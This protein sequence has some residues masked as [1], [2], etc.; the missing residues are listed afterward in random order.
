MPRYIAVVDTKSRTVIESYDVQPGE[1]VATL[2]VLIEAQKD[3]TIID[4]SDGPAPAE[5]SAWRA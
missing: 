2:T 5:G 1:V 4:Y 3:G